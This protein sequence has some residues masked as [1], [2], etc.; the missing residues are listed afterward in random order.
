[1]YDP[2]LIKS[3]GKF[4]TEYGTKLVDPTAH[5]LN[6]ANYCRCGRKPCQH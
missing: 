4:T 1:M 2:Q 3:D 5:E 6:E